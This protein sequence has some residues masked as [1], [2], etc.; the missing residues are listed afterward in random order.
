MASY[1]PNISNGTCYYAENTETKGQFI[2]CGNDAIQVWPCCQLGSYCLSLGDA[3]AC[4]DAK[5]GNTY[6]AGCTDPSFVSPNCLRKPP[7][8]HEQ[9]WVAINQACKDLNANSGSDGITNWTGCVIDNNS[10]ELVKLPMA[11]CTPYC[12]SADIMYAGTSSLEA[13]AS[14]PTITGSSIFWQNDF[15]PPP[16]PAVGYTPGTTNGVVPTSRPTGSPSGGGGL[17]TGAKAGI[18]VGAAVGGILL[19]AILASLVVACLRRR[20][21]QGNQQPPHDP[22]NMSPGTN[23]AYMG[24]GYHQHSQDMT[25]YPPSG[26]GHPSPPLPYTNAYYQ[27]NM[28][29]PAGYD[30]SQT[31]A[32]AY[33]GHKSELADTGYTTELPADERFPAHNLSPGQQSQP[34]QG[35]SPLSSTA[36]TMLTASPPSVSAMRHTASTRTSPQYSEGHGTWDT[37]SGAGTWR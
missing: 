26:G 16:T 2:P 10:T 5:T 22:S 4:W 35:H 3:N 31:P 15:V 18:G 13:Y 30:P 17:S 11:S 12:S 23:A 6:V 32:A 36:S 21:R 28:V 14:L 8:F 20:K 24:H 27:H 7:T 29:S 9:E 1:N 19:I 25:T 37:G 34:G 33:T